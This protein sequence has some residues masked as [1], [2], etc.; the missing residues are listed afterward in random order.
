MTFAGSLRRI[1]SAS[2]VELS[3]R[4][5]QA[6]AEHYQLLV[7]WNRTHNLTRV[8]D[9]E[10]AV[11]LHYL[12]CLAPLLS[13]RAPSSFLDVGSGAGF[14]GLMAM[15]A[16][17]SATAM[18]V[19]P[20]RKRASF[21]TMA[22]SRMGVALAAERVVR[23]CGESRSE[24]VLSRATFSPGAR[25]QLVGCAAPGGEI[26]VWGHHHDVSTWEAEVTTW[27][28]SPR[29]PLG[30]QVDGVEQRCLLR[31]YLARDQ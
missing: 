16:W 8:V 26:V 6:C 12:D 2:G 18:L 5:V 10:Q 9:E 30:Y 31:A 17:P 15:L 14:P 1:G 24:R 7:T 25:R 11:R 19:E 4:V 22:A 20:A 13:W 29:P 3:E 27:G 21:L 28:W 23:R